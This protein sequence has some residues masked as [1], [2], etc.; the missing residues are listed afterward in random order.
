MNANFLRY[1]TLKIKL[2]MDDL[3]FRP[4]MLFPA[5]GRSRKRKFFFSGFRPETKKSLPVHP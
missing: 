1:R 4:L 5:S 2:Y 3:F